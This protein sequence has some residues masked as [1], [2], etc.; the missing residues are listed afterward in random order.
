MR[1]P[2]IDLG[3]QFAVDQRIHGCRVSHIPVDNKRWLIG[4][5]LEHKTRSF[6]PRGLY[7][8]PP[9]DDSYD[10]NRRRGHN[11]G[12][13]ERGSHLSQWWNTFRRDHSPRR[14][15]LLDTPSLGHGRAS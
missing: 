4:H 11:T 12:N 10:I 1:N 2:A 14:A 6:G 5:H 15:K 7:N 13:K 8:H 9:F 3:T